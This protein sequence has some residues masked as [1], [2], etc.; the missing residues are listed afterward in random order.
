MLNGIRS[1]TSHMQDKSVFQLYLMRDID[2]YRDFLRFK[3]ETV[4]CD[5]VKI[6]IKAYITK[7]LK[8]KK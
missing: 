1:F 8:L 4:I 6:Q 2:Q 7:T 5:K 3:L